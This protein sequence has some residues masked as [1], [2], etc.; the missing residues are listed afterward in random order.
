MH[1]EIVVAERSGLCKNLVE[2][3]KHCS[4]HLSPPDVSGITSSLR[5][6]MDAA[7]DIHI[8]ADT[9][10]IYWDE[11]QGRQQKQQP[12]EIRES[13][14]LGPH[15]LIEHIAPHELISKSCRNERLCHM[16]VIAF[17]DC[18]RTVPHEA[19]EGNRSTPD[20]AIPVPNVGTARQQQKKR[21]AF[22]LAVRSKKCESSKLR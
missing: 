13:L 12:K 3:N 11:R 4:T 1:L 9:C 16:G 15:S 6:P 19:S 20:S 22:R 8:A 14:I 21:P 10:K 2:R 7:A 18:W 5:G 17:R